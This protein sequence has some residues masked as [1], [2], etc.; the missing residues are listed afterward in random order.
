M[1]EA[2]FYNTKGRGFDPRWGYLSAANPSSRTV[3]LGFTQ[4]VTEMSTGRFLE[5]KSGRLVRLAT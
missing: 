1:V 4:P 5:V 3:T 2:L